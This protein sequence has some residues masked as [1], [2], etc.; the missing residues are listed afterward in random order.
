MMKEP[1]RILSDL[2]LGHHISR[3]G[4]V[5]SLRPLIA[6]AGTVVFNGDTW[7]ELALRLRARS[8]EMLDELQ[9]MCREE[10]ADAIFLPGN[11]DPGWPGE[12][13]LELAGGRV[14]VT[15]GD[16][17]YHDSAPWSRHAARKREQ[18]LKI[19]NDRAVAETDVATRFEVAR[20]V[21]RLLA[22]N[23]FPQGRAFWQRAL[24]A[25]FPPSRA[26]K[27]LH[28]WATMGGQGASYADRYFPDAKILIFGHFHRSGIWNRRGRLVINTGAFMSPCR[29]M[30]VEW[31]DGVLTCVEID[32]SGELYRP[33]KIAGSWRLDPIPPRSM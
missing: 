26:L 13:W 24:D 14:V 21:A 9:S 33:G 20:E 5:E 2:H 17:I 31:H 30:F 7:Q 1:V 15:H 23:D 25:A 29:A 28:V 32:E 11:H 18:I 22:P 4:R 8:Q 3:V 12:G 27:M 6:G 16:T 10:G 19:W